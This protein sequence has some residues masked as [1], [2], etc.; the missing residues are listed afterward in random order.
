LSFNGDDSKLSETK[1]G[2]ERESLQ[3]GLLGTSWSVKRSLKG[4][5]DGVN[6][7]AF[8]KGPGLML[9]TA[10]N[11]CTTRVWSLDST[12]VMSGK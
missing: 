6:A 8:T 10:G 2:S 4:H 12:S 7:V 9:A 11:D 3:N 5:L 1:H